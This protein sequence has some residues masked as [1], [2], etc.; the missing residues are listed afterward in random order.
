MAEYK[1][2]AQKSVFFLYTNDKHTE[3]EI[4]EIIPF[5]KKK[6]AINLSKVMKILYN[7]N[8]KTLKKEIQEDARSGKNNW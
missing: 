8:I 4:S 7:E 2:K 6:T 1:I 3:K 5:F